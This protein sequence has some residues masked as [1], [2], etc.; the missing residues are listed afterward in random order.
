MNCLVAHCPTAGCYMRLPVCTLASDVRP[1]F[2]PKPGDTTRKWITAAM[3]IAAN[4]ASG[5]LAYALQFANSVLD[6]MATV[7]LNLELAFPDNR[8][9]PHAEWWI[10]VFR[11]WCRVDLV[12]RSWVEHAASYPLEFRLF[13]RRELGLPQVMGIRE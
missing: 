12:R 9:S 4:P 10:C 11:R 3:T 5:S 7:Y 1:E 13:A 2:D 8:T 6:F